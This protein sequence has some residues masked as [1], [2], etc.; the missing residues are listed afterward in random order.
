MVGERYGDMMWI[1]EKN[2]RYLLLKDIWQ[3]FMSE[4]TKVVAAVRG[5]R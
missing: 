3:E 1:D 2:Q 4:A 5:Q